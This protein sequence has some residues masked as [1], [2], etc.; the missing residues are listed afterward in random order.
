MGKTNS[1]NN[2]YVILSIISIFLLIAGQISA[3]SLRERLRSSDSQVRCDAFYELFGRAEDRRN[4]TIE[5]YGK[6]TKEIHE[7]LGEPTSTFILEYNKTRWL[8]IQFLFESCPTGALVEE[9]ESCKKGWRFGPSLLFRD[10]ISVSSQ[11]FS[12]ETGES[13]YSVTPEHLKFKKGG[14]FP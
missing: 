4:S 5:I 11:V 12:D 1:M 7:L 2:R 10:G 3:Q 9:K 6:T 8:R 14:S 13:R